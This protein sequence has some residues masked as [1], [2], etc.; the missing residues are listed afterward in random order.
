MYPGCSP[1]LRPPPSSCAHVAYLLAG[2]VATGLE[3]GRDGVSIADGAEVLLTGGLQGADAGWAGVG[4]PD[5]WVYTM[6]IQ[7]THSCA[8]VHSDGGGPVCCGATHQGGS[9]CLGRCR[10]QVCQHLFHLSQL[11]NTDVICVCGVVGGVRSKVA[12]EASAS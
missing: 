4:G 9:C 6:P 2:L 11:L 8:N 7:Y 12:L 1:Y 10:G 5:K 3:H